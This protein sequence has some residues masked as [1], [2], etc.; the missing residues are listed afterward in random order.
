MTTELNLA[1]SQNLIAINK[2][3][4]KTNTMSGSRAKR[5]VKVF[6]GLVARVFKGKEYAESAFGA[7]THLND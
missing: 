2:S 1:T 6:I 7:S 5:C 3:A 4:S